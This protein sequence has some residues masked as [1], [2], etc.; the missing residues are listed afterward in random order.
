MADSVQDRFFEFIRQERVRHEAKWGE[1]NHPDVDVSLTS[2]PGGCT[3][4]RMTKHYEVPSE[5]RAKFNCQLDASRG[6]LTWTSILIEE[7]SKAI[8]AAT[9]AQQGQGPEENVDTE[10]IQ[11]A[12]V[13]LAWVEARDR[14]RNPQ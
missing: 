4:Q 10:L 12:A 5:G 11:C 13:I 1:Q 2:R 14:R 3:P 7:V 9:L 8:E 6:C